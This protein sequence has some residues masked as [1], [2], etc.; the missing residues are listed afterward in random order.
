MSG[1]TVQNPPGQ[2]SVYDR[3]TDPIQF[4]ESMGK[5][6]WESKAAGCQ[7]LAEGKLL[8]LACMSE[9]M[10]PFD[11]N[12]TYHLMEGKLAMRADS[13]LAK[14]RGIGGKYKWVKDGEDGISASLSLTYDGETITSTYSIEQA[15]QANLVKEK[16]NWAKDPASMLRARVISRGIRMIAPEVIAGTYTPEELSDFTQDDSPPAKTPK[17]GKGASTEKD[18]VI[19]VE[20]IP[21]VS[22]AQSAP[23]EPEKAAGTTSTSVTVSGN[24][25]TETTEKPPFEVEQKKEEVAPTTP[26]QASISEA[27]TTKATPASDIALIMVD[28]ELNA[29]KAGMSMD[30]L[31]KKIFGS[32]GKHLNELNEQQLRNVLKIVAGAAE[33]AA[34]N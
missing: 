25:V 34:G 19:D 28:V 7:T 12:R 23:A 1:L 4:I 24:P 16:G 9:R 11:I 14:F 33:K 20:V 17:R 5:V 29:K 6:F 13:M 30:D 15:K 22:P 21:A 8:A 26:S 32:T 3:I 27:G 31:D 2:L 10:N 18:E